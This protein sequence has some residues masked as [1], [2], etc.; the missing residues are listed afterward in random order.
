MAHIERK[1]DK[2]GVDD[3]VLMSTLSEA[4]VVSHLKHRFKK[5]EI[6]TYIG[7][8]LLSVNPFRFV[9]GMYSSKMIRKYEK[10]YR[11]ELPPHVFAVAEEAFRDMLSK[12]RD[13][14]VLI[15][16]ESGAGKTEA[17]KKVLEYVTEIAPSDSNFGTSVKDKLLQSN[18]L[19]EAFGNAKTNRNDNSSRFGKYMEIQFSF[20]GVPEG[21]KVSNY[22]LEKPRVVGPA[23]GERNFHIFYQ[24]LA[25]CSDEDRENLMLADPS[26]YNY[27][28]QSGCYKVKTINDEDEFSITM[29]AMDA[30]GIAPETQGEIVRMLSGILWLGNI[31]FRETQSSRGASSELADEESRNS[32]ERA[33]S[34]LSVSAD[35]LESALTNRTIKAR[36][37]QFTKPLSQNEAIYTRDAFA[38]ALYSKNFTMLV[39]QLNTQLDSSNNSTSGSSSLKLKSSKGGRTHV[40]LGILDIYGFEIFE[41]NSFEQLCINFCNEKLQQLFIELTLKTEQEE[42]AAEGIKWEH[43]K[44]FNNVVVCDL[45]EAKRPAGILAYLDEECVMPN[46]TD[47]TFL[48]KC[49][50]Q[51]KKHEH[52]DISE[53][54]QKFGQNENLEFTIKHY[55]G[56]VTYSSVNMLQKN[57]DTLFEDL[58]SLAKS[59]SSGF[60]NDIFAEDIKR[61]GNHKRPPT[62][63]YQ[64]KKQ[65]NALIN[66]LKQCE[67]H[68]IRCIK[69]NDEKRSGK[70]DDARVQHQA[71]YLGLLENVRVRRAGF[72]YR[73]KYIDFVRRYKMLS[74]STWPLHN[75]DDLAGDTEAILNNCGIMPGKNDGDTYV[76]GKTKVFIR[77]PMMLFTLEELR[78][79]KLNDIVAVIQG[80]YRAWKARKK[81]LELREKALGIFK[82]R[83]RRR[84]SVHLFFL[85]DYTNASGDPEMGRTMEKFGDSKIL[86]ADTVVKYNEKFKNQERIFVMTDKHLYNV[87]PNTFKLRRKIALMDIVALS[88]STMA[89]NYCVI[90]T[91]GETENDYLFRCLHKAEF[92]TT[93]SEEMESNGYP[94]ELKFADSFSFK[95]HKPSFF[96]KSKNMIYYQITFH[97]ELG[98]G[99]MSTQAVLEQTGKGE[100]ACKVSVGEALCSK[101]N[102]QL[103]ANYGANK[104]PTYKMK[105]KTF[106]KSYTSKKT[107]TTSSYSSS[108]TLHSAAN[109]SK[110]NNVSHATSYAAKNTRMKMGRTGG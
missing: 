108:S 11:Y 5:D 92:A 60:I 85:G 94:F 82:G 50:K 80:T 8:V 98:M 99:A 84:G 34:L 55:A 48:H 4:S 64:F 93:L 19:L 43:I 25:G 78:D 97:E 58:V 17:A 65:M 70:F 100:P 22:L 76:M 2:K 27:L 35:K 73:T 23:S 47:A 16:G 69:P 10:R 12:S 49:E 59:S 87:L 103:Q 3:L 28:N 33:A 13:H 37:E 52:F 61:L 30:I 101:A 1:F 62:A 18:P 107:T 86:F 79:R 90:H 63:G 95:N 81:F 83:K 109:E 32:L 39:Q 7:P 72:A 105:K 20:N 91:R 56:P 53:E 68:Y 46:G 66:T 40:Q 110:G 24:L 89:D 67:P 36:G 54:A 38:K 26:V 71:Q 42:Y 57:K 45:I 106:T 88:L 21:G 31:E 51:L 102:I 75:P 104:L 74:E 29:E 6:Y 96:G 14:C 41:M 77:K 44:Y 9:K 15:S